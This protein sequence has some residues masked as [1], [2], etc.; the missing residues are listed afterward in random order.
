MKTP[1]M[2]EYLQG[3]IRHLEKIHKEEQH[4]ITEAAKLVAQQV[5]QDKLVFAY[6]PGGHSNLGSQELFFRAGG[7]MHISAMLDEG[8]LLSGGALRSMAIERTPGYG[9]I[10]I[11][12]YG[13]VKD[14]LLIIVN[15]YGINAATIDA[16]LEAKRRGVKTIGVTSVEHASSTPADHPARHPSKQNLHELVDVVLDSKVGVGDA[17]LQ[18]SGLEQ[19]VAA[20]STFANA[21]LLNAMTAEA[22]ALLV[23][24][25]IQ[26]PIWMSGNA[27]GGDE[28]NAQFIDRFKGKIKKL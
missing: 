14:D 13:L 5:K 21:Y 28:W 2:T 27:S 3:I 17:I 7:L 6:G 19:K 26:P 20:I 8:T 1:L 25:G 4:A 15:A 18:I 12:D 24:E 23:A 9:K 10:V 22:I 16:A 11:E